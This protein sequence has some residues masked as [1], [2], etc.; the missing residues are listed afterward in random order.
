MLESIPV[1]RY[2]TVD[3]ILQ[4]LN[5]PSLGAAIPA[6]PINQAAP[7]LPPTF[8]SPTPSQVDL[9][10]EELKTQFLP[11]GKVKPQNIQPQTTNNPPA[12]KSEIDRELEELKAKYLGENNL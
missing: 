8:I 2:Q 1:R 3:E 6:K 7:T 5:Q 10:L 12:N 9:E 11:G 4:E